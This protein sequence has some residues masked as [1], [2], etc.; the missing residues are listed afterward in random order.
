MPHLFLTSK[1]KSKTHFKKVWLPHLPHRL[2]C[3]S[4]AWTILSQLLVCW[5]TGVPNS[6]H[7][8]ALSGGERQ[9]PPP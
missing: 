9:Y 8:Q 5:I 2:A 7:Y 1:G 4:Q 3:S 6:L